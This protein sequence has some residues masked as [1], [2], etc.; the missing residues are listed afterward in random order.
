MTVAVEQ[1]SK[2]T[3][4]WAIPT[5]LSNSLIVVKFVKKEIIMAFGPPQY[6]LSVNDLKFD[7]K[8]VQVF[9]H[10]FY[11]QW[12]CASTYNPQENGVA[13]RTVGTLKR[14]LQYVTQSECKE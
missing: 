3:V 7:C 11:M 1:M 4:A 8:A 13:E 12:E 6:I 14:A 2:W 9:A 10:R 5:E